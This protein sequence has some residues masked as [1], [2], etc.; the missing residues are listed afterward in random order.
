MSV[1]T[2][3]KC[4]FCEFYSTSHLELQRHN[5]QH[6][7]IKYSCVV[8]PFSSTKKANLNQHI[9]QSHSPKTEYTCTICKYVCRS[10][11]NFDR[12]SA[13]HEQQSTYICLVCPVPVQSKYRRNI[14][15]HV[16]KKHAEL[17]LNPASYIG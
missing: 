5:N 6:F 17:P 8:C 4:I 7:S 13:R 11:T 9:L 14:L 15:R 16:K 1:L 3:K 2:V 10:Q 12:H